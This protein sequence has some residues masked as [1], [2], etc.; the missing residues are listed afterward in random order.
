M[1][2]L[3]STL[4]REHAPDPRIQTAFNVML[5]F[6]STIL[7]LLEVMATREGGAGVSYD[8]CHTYESLPAL[9]EGGMPRLLEIFD[10]CSRY[11]IMREHPPFAGAVEAVN[12]LAGLG[13]RFHLKTE[14]PA[15]SAEDTRR[16]LDEYSIPY[17]SF[18]CQRPLDKVAECLRENIAIAIDDHTQFIADAS[19]A[20]ITVMT[21]GYPYNARICHERGCIHARN[22]EELAPH[23]VTA[24]E[25][26][27][28]RELAQR[29]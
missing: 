27:I 29:I 9:V 5:D 12:V 14:R 7:P 18:R 20:A 28:K 11:E 22:W 23:V 2:E 4:M 10:E 13:V 26:E 6:D 3:D 19:S 21:L 24:V 25:S 15:D 1:K 17:V 8:V 16:Y